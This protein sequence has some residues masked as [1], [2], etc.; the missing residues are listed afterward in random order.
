MEKII[1][2]TI[3]VI[4]PIFNAE[5]Y[6]SLALESILDQS[7]CDFEL[8]LINDG[9]TDNSLNI[10]RKF[11]QNDS[12]I[13]LINNDVNRGLIPSLNLGLRKAK[14][15]YIARM[16]A[17]DICTLDR[18]EF[19]VDYL[20]NHPE[21]F[22]VAGSFY[23]IDENGN[24]LRKKQKEYTN[25]QIKSK[26][27][28]SGIIHHPT[29][30]F[31]NDSSVYYRDKLTHGEDRDL[32]LRFISEGK[33]MYMSTKIV[34]YY[35]IHEKS[36]S[37]S[38]AL[39]Q[40]AYIKKVLE[41]H[42]QRVKTGKDSYEFFD[43]K[44]LIKSEGDLNETNKRRKIKLVFL[45]DFDSVTVLNVI[46]KYWKD[47]GFFSWYTSFFLYLICIMPENLSMFIRDKIRKNWE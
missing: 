27:L 12:R 5:T 37:S 36:I 35:R 1:K 6:L 16:D 9:S 7:F 18:F 14:G 4:M 32:W 2:P 46:R 10:I 8:I 21:I 30:M 28:K 29:V 44:T 25:E 38:T 45:S 17:D 23:I 39:T 47:E 19:Q 26:L 11:Q 41:W 15:K 43:P 3:S 22:L 34:L 20:N 42:S 13:I 24:I 33:R 40:R 31:R